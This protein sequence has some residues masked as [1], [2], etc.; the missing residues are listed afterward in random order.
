VLPRV[1]ARIT[2]LRPQLV[3]RDTE[4]LGEVGADPF[5][6]VRSSAT[7]PKVYFAVS[8]GLVDVPVSHA[9]IEE[10]T[11]PRS[12]YRLYRLESRC[13]HPRR[14]I[15]SEPVAA[16]VHSVADV[17]PGRRSRTHR[18]GIRTAPR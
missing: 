3:D 18:G 15:D 17:A 4:D 14:P 2:P 5:L 12:D 9:P 8:R 13:S 7:V 6:V 11:R 16:H 10:G 1:L